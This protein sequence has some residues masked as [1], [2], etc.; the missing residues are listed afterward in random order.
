VIKA[1]IEG[2]RPTKPASTHV[3]WL[4]WGLTEKIWQ[5]ME[6]CWESEPGERPL[7][8]KIVKLMP[9]LGPNDRL[10]DTRPTNSD[11]Y[12]SPSA[13]RHAVHA[14]LNPLSEGMI[15]RVVEW[16]REEERSGSQ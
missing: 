9:C 11:E 4:Q 16:L 5:L 1:T 7:A 8:S 3:A 13:F 10:D 2:K 15:E 12:L 14:K 6:D